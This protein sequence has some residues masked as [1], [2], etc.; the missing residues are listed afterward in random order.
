M[1]RLDLAP[2]RWPGE[3]T[4]FYAGEGLLAISSPNPVRDPGPAVFSAWLRARD[5]SHLRRAE[6]EFRGNWRVLR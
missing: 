4:R 1:R 6:D 3:P 5:E 2:W